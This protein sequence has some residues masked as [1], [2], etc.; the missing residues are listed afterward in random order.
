M[1][2]RSF[3]SK[4]EDAAV[5]DLT[6]LRTAMVRIFLRVVTVFGVI[7]V[8]SSYFE[9]DPLFALHLAAISGVILVQF[10][11]ET[12]TGTR[13]L[14]LFSC[15][16][17]IGLSE[18]IT[19][20]VDGSSVEYFTLAVFS[21]VLLSGAR[22]GFAALGWCFISTLVFALLTQGKII[23]LPL[24]LPRHDI[25]SYRWADTLTNLLLVAGSIM[26]ATNYVITRLG[27][28]LGNA[29]SLVSRLQHEVKDKERA[30]E[31][32]GESEQRYRLLADN[33]NDVVWMTDLELNNL[34]ISPSIT[35]QRGLSVEEAMAMTIEE[36]VSP[37]TYPTLL[38]KFAESVRD[39][40][41]TEDEKWASTEF[42]VLCKDGSYKWVEGQTSFLRDDKDNP[43]AILG[44]SRDISERK[45][46]EMTRGKLEAQLLQSQKMESVGQLAGGVAHDFN[47]ILVAILGY[48]QLTKRDKELSE[49]SKKNLEEVLKAAGRARVLTGQ[50]L[51]FARR[52]VIDPI[53]LNLNTMLN[54]VQGM[55]DRL[56]PENIA[57]DVALGDDIGLVKGDLGQ[58][59]QVVVN[60]VVNA[61]DAMPNGGTL[62][63]QTKR[64]S[65]AESVLL[66]ELE[67]CE[68][69]FSMVSISDTGEG[70]SPETL[71]LVFEP[72]FT[73]KSEG[74]GTGLG[75]SV[76]YGIVK[77]LGGHISLYSEPGHGTEV[78]I[79]L[80]IVERGGVRDIAQDDTQ[81]EPATG[82][83]SILLVEDDE[84]VRGLARTILVGAGYTVTEANDG[85]EALQQ[86]GQHKD[87]LDLIFLDVVMPNMSGEEVMHRIREE[88]PNIP[89][90]FSSGYSV[91]TVHTDFIL[92]DGL[93]LL[94]KPYNYESLLRKVREVLDQ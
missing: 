20:G 73:T 8:T 3:L 54:N 49:K 55:L 58:L 80:P 85:Q 11:S 93:N 37:E 18:I 21:A 56:I 15:I 27:E 39:A 47:N 45:N 92:N 7:A 59:E 46:V 38:L 4:A 2:L 71:G 70:M 63:I 34:Y 67:N 33:I 12:F 72:F 86:Y 28:S 42:E 64:V 36:S 41:S 19:D 43:I 25:G 62:A 1:L 84:Q 17:L 69:D 24:D 14:V 48:T 78:R 6:E 61:C 35:Q 77:Q 89:I 87:S 16:Y 74:Q 23:E 22:A 5:A 90:L 31:Q 81:L 60:V 94:P 83:E 52:Q 91:G 44:V 9:H 40:Q 57:I 13:S 30:M 75:M 29:K 82:S 65:R 26:M 66:E 10:T 53:T 79:Y 50:L 76:V 51:A 68:A 88:N 32:S